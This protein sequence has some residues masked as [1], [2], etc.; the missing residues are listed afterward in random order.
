MGGLLKTAPERLFEP[1][2]RWLG[3][4][5]AAAVTLSEAFEGCR[6]R[7]YD[8]GFGFATIGIGSRRYLDGR[9]VTL[10]GPAITRAEA[11]AMAMRDLQKAARLVAEAVQVPLTPRQAAALIL[12]ANNI[13]ALT[14]AAPS[15]VNLVNAGDWPAAASLMKIYRNSGGRPVTGLRRRRWAEAAFS[16]GMDP[17]EARARAWALID[18][19][20]DWPK[21][22][23]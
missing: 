23:G 14:I 9:P 6:L 18:S 21:L 15:L 11:E 13:G 19:P 17:F 22:P 7:P 16:L 8:A 4:V 1:E 5:P 3:G 12:L 10:A 20:D 2:E